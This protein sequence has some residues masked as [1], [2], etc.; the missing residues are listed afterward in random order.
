MASIRTK[1]LSNGKSAYLVRFRAADGQER[2]RQ[3]AR[4]RDAERFAHLIEVDRSQGSFV[5]PRLGKITVE[6]WFER[7]WPTVTNL[8]PTTRARDEASFRNHVLP[9]FGSMPLS[10]VDRTSLREWVAR[11]SDPDDGGLAPATVSKAVQVFNKAMRAALEDR[12]ISVNPVERLPLP[13]IEREEMRFL[14][15]DELRRLADTIDARYRAFV[16]LAGYSGLR[17]GE[18]LALRWEQR[19]HAPASGDG[20]RDAHRPRRPTELRPTE[21]TRRTSDGDRSELRRRGAFTPCRL[22]A[23]C[24]QPRVH[25]SLMVT[26]FDRRCSAA[27]SGTRP[28]R[29]LALAL[30][31]S[32]TCA[33]PPS[34]CGSQPVRTRSRSQRGRAT[35]VC[36]SSSTATGTCSRSTMVS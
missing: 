3:F 36:P 30:C 6:D 12:L 1:R 15:P 13:K 2:S 32:T 9:T 10:R 25:L 34:R 23:G 29:R 33:T 14:T 20:D 35:R 16:L 31:A 4:R 11:L 7:W 27:A 19:R 8:R 24:S 5:D 28:S 26:R 17:V 22:T 18:L 21:D